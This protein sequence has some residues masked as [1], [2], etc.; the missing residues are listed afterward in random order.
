MFLDK[1]SKGVEGRCIKPAQPNMKFVAS[2]GVFFKIL[3][4]SMT[5]N[6]P[7]AHVVNGG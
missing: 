7:G 3:G 1:S 2:L 6:H 4:S 5:L